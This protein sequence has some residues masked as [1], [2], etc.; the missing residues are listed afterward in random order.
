MLL[1]A[2]ERHWRQL[3]R[4]K[5]EMIEQEDVSGAHPI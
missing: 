5:V 2:A 3:P 1:C 4:T